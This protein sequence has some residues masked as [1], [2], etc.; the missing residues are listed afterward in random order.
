MTPDEIIDQVFRIYRERGHRHYGEDVTETQHAL[1]CATFARDNGEDPSLVAACLLHDFGHL[2][3]D[4]GEDIADRGV[5]ARH[6][7]LG[8]DVLKKWFSTEIVEP[9][10]MHVAA[11]R[12]LCARQTGYFEGLSEASRLSL[13]LQGGPMTEAEMKAFE[14]SPHHAAAVRLRLYDDMGKVAEMETPDFESFRPFLKPF[15]QVGA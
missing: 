7:D 13:E 1:Q 14:T 8:A 6:E 12:Y 3:H 2:A 15:V 9:V 4:L 10:R 11:K 5:D